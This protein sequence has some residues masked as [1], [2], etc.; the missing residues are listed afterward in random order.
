L[1]YAADDTDVGIIAIAT[2]F[3]IWLLSSCLRCVT[4]Y[5]RHQFNVVCVRLLIIRDFF[6]L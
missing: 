1:Y 5:A 6:Y 4:F 3:H 2:R